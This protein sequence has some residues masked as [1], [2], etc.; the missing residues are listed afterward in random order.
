MPIAQLRGADDRP[1]EVTV[2]LPGGSTV[3]AHVWQAQVGRVPLLM[4]DSD[5][6]ANDEAVRGVTDRLYGG[7]SEHRL[8]Q[9]M[10]LGI[11]G[12]RALRLFRRLTGA[13]EPEVYHTNEGHAGFLG[14]ERISELVS[15]E[16]MTF[17]E[18][19]EVVRAAT[20]F[21][22]HT[23]VPAGIDR[24]TREMIETY[25][26]GENELPG[27]PVGKLLA[28]GAEDYPGGDPSMFNMAVMGL[29]LAQRA[30]GVSRL[31]GAVSRVDA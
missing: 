15:Q 13:P 3:T 9:E 5:I 20:V 24:F 11:G 12:V 27:V 31:H 21:T 18:A 4:L 28:L 7:S 14:I 22:T 30:N 6:E 23:P 2:D 17:D 25:F 10:L 1:A 29:R 26:G 16:R 19:L 8:K